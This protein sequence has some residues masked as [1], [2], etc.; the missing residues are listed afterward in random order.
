M[1]DFK[2]DFSIGKN[3]N[4]LDSGSFVDFGNGTAARQSIIAAT[5]GDLRIPVALG[6]VAGVTSDSFIGVNESFATA[7]S[8][9]IIFEGGAYEYLT[10]AQSLLVSSTNNGS[11]NAP[12]VGC[13]SVII[14]GLDENYFAISEV[15]IMN[16]TTKVSTVNSYKRVNN[17][18][19]IELMFFNISVVFINV[20]FL[21]GS[22]LIG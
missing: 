3:R 4:D 11:D 8:Q 17:F 20:A 2:T 19:V 16:G 9:D 18:F 7:A 22:S 12:G 21:T 5:F 14:F 13:R 6:L 1:T 10:T 15:L